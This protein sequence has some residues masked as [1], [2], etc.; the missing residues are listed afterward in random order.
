MGSS[1]Y[2]RSPQRLQPERLVADVMREQSRHDEVMRAQRL[3]VARL[4]LANVLAIGKG[5]AQGVAPSRDIFG[6]DEV[7]GDRSSVQLFG[8]LP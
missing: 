1:V 8:E 4:Q 3:L 2:R 7:H 6:L 5:I